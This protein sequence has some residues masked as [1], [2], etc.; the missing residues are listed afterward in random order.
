QLPGGSWQ[1]LGRPRH[2]WAAALPDPTVFRL[3]IGLASA[4]VL[5]PLFLARH[6]INER[7]RHIRALGERQHQLDVL[8]R[9]LGLALSTSEVGVWEYDAELDQLFWDDR[10]NEL[11]GQPRNAGP[12][13][14]RHW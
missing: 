8:S 6:L 13:A 2:G 14:F 10:M 9:R 12:R 11:Y 4:L 1:I 7:A 3:L 5:V